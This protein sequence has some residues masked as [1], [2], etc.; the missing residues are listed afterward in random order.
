[1]TEL[2]FHEAANIFPL[3]EGNIPALAKDI[4][5]NGQVVPIEIMDGK[6]LDGRRRYKACLMAGVKPDYREV[7]V[8]DPVKHVVSLN[9]ERRHLDASDRAQVAFRIA[10]MKQG[11]RTDINQPSATL[12]E[13]S[14]AEAAEMM[15]VSERLVNAVG[16]VK[17]SGSPETIAAM[18]SGEITVSAA[19]KKV[20]AESKPEPKSEPPKPTAKPQPKAT[21]KSPPT[22]WDGVVEQLA[23]IASAIE[24]TG[25]IP[26]GE[27]PWKLVESLES[28]ASVLLR[29]AHELRKKH[30]L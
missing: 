4:Q 12:Q 5:E 26:E 6:I 3:D 27:K 11:R 8:A 29:R 17:N 13:V 23:R 9:L 22:P 1:M 2:E 24:S 28:T 10:N 30:H 15:N 14:R 18:E 19:A 16:S 21:V 20:R 25:P 7:D